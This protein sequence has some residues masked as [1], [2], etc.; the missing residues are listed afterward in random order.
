MKRVKG[1]MAFAPER[2]AKLLKLELKTKISNGEIDIR[3]PLE[4]IKLT[5]T[6][7][8]IEWGNSRKRNN[9]SGTKI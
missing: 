5:S 1:D 9:L 6:T 4:Q 3:E 8:N 2:P 7:V